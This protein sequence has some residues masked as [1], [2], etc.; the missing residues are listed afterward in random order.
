MPQPKL[1]FHTTL[2]L[3]AVERFCLDEILEAFTK[4]DAILQDLSNKH[5]TSHQMA[6]HALAY[7]SLTSIKL[8]DRHPSLSKPLPAQYAHRAIQRFAHQARARHANLPD[9][10]PARSF[11]I[12]SRCAD[13]RVADSTLAITTM[14]SR[15][16]V[17]GANRELRLPLSLRIPSKADRLALASGR[18]LGGT[19]TVSLR[20]P[21]KVTLRL[22]PE[23]PPQVSQDASK[24]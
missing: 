18:L 19:I 4:A 17:G 6:L 16:L 20:G 14:A 2:A 22:Q 12:D 11:D 15:G 1:V 7:R 10:Y 9:P 8:E 13:L 21:A 3:D 5:R 23:D 24:G